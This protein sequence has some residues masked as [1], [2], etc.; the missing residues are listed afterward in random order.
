MIMILSTASCSRIDLYI[1]N[2]EY[3][4]IHF[5]HAKAGQSVLHDYLYVSS[6]IAHKSEFATRTIEPPLAFNRAPYPPSP[7]SCGISSLSWC[8]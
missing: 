7:T 1:L 8:G 6:A 5:I 2:F 4:Y 3:T